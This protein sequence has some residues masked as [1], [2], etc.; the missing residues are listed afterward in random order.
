MFA[1]CLSLVPSL[2]RPATYYNDVHQNHQLGA[3]TLSC[4]LITSI[5]LC[6]WSFYNIFN[7]DFVVRLYIINIHFFIT[8]FTLI[9]FFVVSSLLCIA[10][11]ILYFT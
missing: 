6:I 10:E 5:L 2:N 11:K 1:L 3:V 8:D 4:M 9:V 7:I